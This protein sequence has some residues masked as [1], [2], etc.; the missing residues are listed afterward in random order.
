MSG[1]WW[2]QLWSSWTRKAY[3]WVRGWLSRGPS[4]RTVRR[5]HTVRES[6]LRTTTR[7]PSVSF[8]CFLIPPA[9][10]IWTFKDAI[11]NFSRDLDR[12]SLTGSYSDRR[13]WQTSLFGFFWISQ[14]LLAWGRS[15]NYF[16]RRI[17]SLKHVLNVK[18]VREG[19]GP[20]RRHR[21]S[22]TNSEE[23][24]E[25]TNSEETTLIMVNIRIVGASK[26]LEEKLNPWHMNLFL[27]ELGA[28]YRL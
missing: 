4:C 20:F 19:L 25:D 23:T 14:S 26:L 2:V 24:T 13:R 5:Y 15:W 7:Q 3:R 22:D 12:I 6:A 18:I 9:V 1:Q 11:I 17:G 28:A 8:L 21:S 27:C 10:T 16:Y